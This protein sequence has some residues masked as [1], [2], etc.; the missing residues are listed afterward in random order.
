MSWG[1]RPTL[2]FV[3]SESAA[4][5]LLLL[6]NDR[7]DRLNCF[8][9]VP[10]LLQEIL[11]LALWALL[12]S[13]S[14]AT[15]DHCGLLNPYLSLFEGAVV[16]FLPGWLALYSALTQP[17]TEVLLRRRLHAWAL[18]CAVYTAFAIICVV[19][20]QLLG[21]CPRCTIAGPWGHQ[22]WPFL[23]IHPRA[24][25]FGHYVNYIM[26]C[27]PPLAIVGRFTIAPVWLVGLY[28]LPAVLH[29]VIGDEWGSFWCFTASLGCFLYVFEP[30]V[31]R[32]QERRL[33]LECP[34]GRGAQKIVTKPT[35]EL[36]GFLRCA[37]SVEDT[38]GAPTLLQVVAD[39]VLLLH[40]VLHNRAF[41][42]LSPTTASEE[43]NATQAASGDILG[44]QQSEEPTEEHTEEDERAAILGAVFQ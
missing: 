30:M 17:A 22:I 37:Q 44:R 10:L 27:L 32:S 41:G 2:F 1:F 35:F 34:T 7:N 24:L 28:W 29:I 11:Q 39:S 23:S 26:L 12:A 42:Y 14:G 3:V 4:L 6:R 20:A 5:L 18:T 8:L 16:G 9:H 25:S 19:I 15:E 13:N 38:Q 43:F 40:Y 33:A 36:P 21:A 31:L